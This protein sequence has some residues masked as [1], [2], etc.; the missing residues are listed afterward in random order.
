MTFRV[1]VT[2]C[3]GLLGGSL[4]RLAPRRGPDGRKIELFGL[5]RSPGPAAGLSSNR[6]FRYDSVDIGD[7]EALLA[8]LLRLKPDFVVNAAALTQ[9]DLC[10]KE[11]ALSHRI[12][13][14]AA[15]TLAESGLPFLQV[16]T[17][18]VFD[19]R[20]GPYAEDDAVNPLSVYGRHKLEAE[21]HA[22]AGAPGSLVVRTMTLWGPDRS[23]GEEEARAQ[24]APAN[25]TSFVDFVKGSLAAGRKI[26]IVTDQTGNPTLAGDLARAV[27]ALLREKRAGLYHAAGGDLLSRFEWARRIAGRYGL[28]ASL[29]EPCL[30]ADLRQ[31]A[32]R[33]LN[34][35]LRCDKLL[36]DTGVRLRR[37]DEQLLHA[38]AGGE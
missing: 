38:D 36:R 5:G 35:G 14:E 1:A 21:G 17:D 22:L 19:G 18:Y 15:R 7:R 24:A 8:L 25:K 16:S 10:E 2:G 3:N 13:A 4:V 37:V 34:S 33:P 12:N 6:P 23:P 11:E 26:R 29:L 31:S 32:P 20:R 30:T 28:D 9:V 27:W